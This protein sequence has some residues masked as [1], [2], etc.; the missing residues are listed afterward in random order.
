MSKEAVRHPVDYRY[1]ALN[2]DFIKAM[3]QIAKYA[4]EKYGD[5]PQYVHTRL[6]KDASP[7]NHIAEHTREYLH[8]EVHDKFG[9]L[10]MQLAAIAYNAMMEFHYLRKFGPADTPFKIEDAFDRR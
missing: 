3:A 2:W 5:A 8:G 7:M 1:D 6:E 9:N 4:D 10:E